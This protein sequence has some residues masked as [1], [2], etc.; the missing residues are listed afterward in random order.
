M[1]EN[2]ETIPQK[3]TRAAKDVLHVSTFGPQRD[4]AADYL[5]GDDRDMDRET[6][7]AEERSSRAAQTNARAQADRQ[8]QDAPKY[9][10]GG[11][12]R[13]TGPARLLKGERVLSR[14]QARSR[15]RS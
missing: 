2:N 15:G 9:H 8:M 5:K 12:V 10:R 1:P 11:K 6:A 4:Q 3:A 14:K 7:R 13:A